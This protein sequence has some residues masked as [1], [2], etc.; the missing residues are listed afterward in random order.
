M[1]FLVE[2]LEVQG[3]RGGSVG[4]TT[5][6][7]RSF[8]PRVRRQQLHHGDRA[9][10]GQR[11]GAGVTAMGGER[12]EP[13][14]NV[15]R[16]DHSSTMRAHR[17]ADRFSVARVETTGPLANAIHKSSSEPALL[18][19]VFVRPVAPPSYQLWSAGRSCRRARSS[20]FTRMWSISTRNPRCGALPRFTAFAS[21]ASATLGF[22]R[23]G[24]AQP[25]SDSAST[26]RSAAMR[27]ATE[28]GDSSADSPRYRTSTVD[29][30][31]APE[32]MPSAT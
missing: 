13:W 15:M 11:L 30:S 17:Y 26:H 5:S 1:R 8:L 16:L 12:L 9:L 25:P 14:T 7:A 2:K 23:A 29:V 28:S 20:P 6:P 22:R 19:S 31:S 10:R 18:V 4:P 21:G 24:S 32:S 3:D 27:A